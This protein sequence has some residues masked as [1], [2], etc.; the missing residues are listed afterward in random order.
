MRNRFRCV[1]LFVLIAGLLGFDGIAGTAFADDVVLIATTILPAGQT[2]VAYAA[3]VVPGDGAAPFRFYIVSGSLPSG[4]SLN[5]GTGWISGT[6]G[7]TGRFYF[8]AGITDEEGFSA[9]ANLYIDV[10]SSS[11]SANVPTYGSGV[12]SDGLAN[13]TIGPWGSELS[14]R[15]RATHSGV[16]QQATIYLIPDISGYSGGNG[17]TI[18]VD[19][20][21]DDGTSA[22]HPSGNILT[23]YFISNAASLP[24]PQRY[25]YV[26]K[27][28]NTPT[29]NAG[30]IYHMTFQNVD[31]NPS[32]NFISVDSLYQATTQSAF[33][34]APSDPS[35]AVLTAWGGGGWAPREGFAPVYELDYQDGAS[36]GIGYV[37]GWV[38]V[39][40]AISGS[41]PLREI[42]TVTGSQTRVVTA[43]V[44]VARVRGEDPVVIR[45]EE[46]DGTMIEEGYIDASNI[47]LSSASSPNYYWATFVFTESHALVPGVTYHLVVECDATSTYQ[48]VALQKGH[49]Y[50]FPSTTFFADGNAEVKVNDS[51]TGW[52]EWG[53]SNRIDDDLQFYFGVVQ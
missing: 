44:R 45:F 13:T 4:L 43:A 42:F 30:Q 29:L 41:V 1:C 6:P 49:Y 27:F 22:H 23:T 40:A 52:T 8:T 24:A 9:S 11:N 18:R 38:G 35:A 15:F 36:E 48:A 53:V 34:P 26:M 47:P 19:I 51:W 12:G 28:S 25:F 17:G 50:G 20:R 5:S 33:P 46:A 32:S 2:G 3:P 37:A 16:L 21:T 39:P 31:S 14:Y 7:S 10:S